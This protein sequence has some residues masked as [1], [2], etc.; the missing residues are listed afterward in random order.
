M[1]NNICFQIYM[2]QESSQEKKLDRYYMNDLIIS[3]KVT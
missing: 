1:L 2:I 3:F